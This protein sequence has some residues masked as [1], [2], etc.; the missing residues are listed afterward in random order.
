MASG[1]TSYLQS[2]WMTQSRWLPEVEYPIF[3]IYKESPMKFPVYS[4][5]RYA[6]PAN[7]QEQINPGDIGYVI[8]DC[9]DGNYDVEFSDPDGTTR[10]LSVI[11]GSDLEFAEK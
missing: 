11:A 2:G 3:W 10:A 4:R 5:V 6:G 8:E 9:G 1:Q 7:L